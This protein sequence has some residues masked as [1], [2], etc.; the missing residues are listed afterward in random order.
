M[1]HTPVAILVRV[2]TLAQETQRQVT[3]LK[4]YA[5]QQGYK[6]VEV[7]EETISGASS[8]RDRTGL[9]KV[10]EMAR[11]GVITKVL[12]HEI[13]RVARKNSVAHQFLETLEEYKVSLYWHQHRIET[14]LPNGNRNPAASIMFSLLAELGREERSTLVTRIKSGIENSRRNGVV[15]G[16]PRGSTVS[17]EDTLSK[18]KDIVRLLNRGSSI[19]HIATLTK[20]STTTVQRIK[21]MHF[22]QQPA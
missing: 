6:V 9:Q 19:R 7:V 15:I 4:E 17:D 13:S 10:E 1:K 3:E 8:R 11:Q 14:L 22:H 16:R 20:K 5:D 2:S 18:H 21:K 12:V